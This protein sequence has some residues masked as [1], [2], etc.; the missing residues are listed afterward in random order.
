MT[1]ARGM[2]VVYGAMSTV[3]G[4]VGMVVFIV[5]VIAFAA[6]ITW[7]VVRVFPAQSERT[8]PPPA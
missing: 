8:P 7:A 5:C 3:L 1:H 4:L 2:E 6:A